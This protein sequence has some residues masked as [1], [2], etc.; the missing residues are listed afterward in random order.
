MS[1]ANNILNN[2]LVAYIGALDIPN[3]GRDAI[4]RF[5]ATG[6]RSHVPAQYLEQTIEACNQ[7]FRDTFRVA[8]V[9]CCLSALALAA[10]DWKAVRDPLD[11]DAD[12]AH[13]QPASRIAEV[14]YSGR[15]AILSVSYEKKRNKRT[16]CL[17]CA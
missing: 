3:L 6:L 14:G 8:L 13:D 15:L 1:A 4:V 2:R 5:G 7:A 11:K 16:R 12:E 10:V 17:P 9:V